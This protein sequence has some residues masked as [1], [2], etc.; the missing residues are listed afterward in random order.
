LSAQ[1]RN[2]KSRRMTTV[3]ATLCSSYQQMALSARTRFIVWC[4]G[5]STENRQYMMRLKHM[6]DISMVTGLTTGQLICDGARGVKMS[7]TRYVSMAGGDF[8]W[9]LPPGVRE[10][11]IPGCRPEDAEEEVTLTLTLGELAEIDEFGLQA[12]C[13]DA[14]VEQ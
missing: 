3:V 12:N 7:A 14:V 6:F 13:L 9:S 5:R 4:A 2:T 1:K 8:G 11:D 10:C